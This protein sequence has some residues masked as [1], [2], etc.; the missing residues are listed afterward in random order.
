MIVRATAVVLC[1]AGVGALVAGGRHDAASQ[2]RPAVDQ[3]VLADTVGGRTAHFLVRLRRQADV[4]T[5]VAGAP[6]RAVQGTRAVA[7]LRRASNGQLGVEAELRRLGVSFHS[8]WVVSAIAVVGG[9][10]VVDALAA[11][12]DVATIEADRAFRGYAAE[13]G[14]AAPTAPQGIEWNVQKIGAPAVWALGYTGQGLVYANADSGVTW[15]VPALKSH[16]RGWDGTIANHNYNWWDAVHGDISG[17]GSTP[18]GFDAKAPCDDDTFTSISHGTHTMGTAVGDDGAGNQV[19]VAPGAKW[20]ACRNEDEGV[21]RPSSYIE[22]LQFFLAPTD[23]NGAN[24]DPA[25]RPN[26]V[27]NSYVCPPEEQCAAG[28]LQA[29]VD[30]LRAAGVFMAVS[31][32]NAG[33]N[34]CS[35]IASPPAIYDSSVSVGATDVGD[36]IAGFS[37]RGPVTI[38]G[39]GRTKPDLVAPGVGVRS[40]S[41]NGYALGSGTSMA[42]PHVGAAVLLLW[43]AFPELR[44]NV[45]AT[46]QLLEQSATHLTTSDGCGADTTIAVPNNTYGYGRLDVYAAFRA[47]EAA[48]PPELGVADVAVAEGDRGRAA[49]VFSVTL[50]RASSRPVRVDFATRRGTAT[51]GADFV[52]TSGSLTFGSGERVKKIPVPVVGDTVRELDE[53][54]SLELSSPENARLGRSQAVATIRNDDTARARPVLTGLRV[55][56]RKQSGGTS[57]T[58]RLRLSLP[59]SVGCVIERRVG[60][61]WR[62]AGTFRRSAPAGASSFL[63]PFLLV[64]GA[65]RLRCVPRDRAGSVGAAVSVAFAVAA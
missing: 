19:G 33:R 32:G 44:G 60:A 17:N 45:D 34:G 57:A 1:A 11:R 53:T 29:A 30:N 55:T 46:E 8:Y 16:Y 59:A 49:A 38:D 5:A 27:G 35:T 14:S 51:P 40:S 36:R 26:A 31:A 47:E 24:P 28:S 48:S 9:R 6:T 25:K 10:R 41:R 7:A 65:Y 50:A 12:S 21:G 64:P 23:L 61:G 20:I 37:S 54:F 15:D 18:C 4:G 62:R 56:T 39:S 52:S 58:V 42:S 43:S 63:A 3:R 13:S 22:C 2:V